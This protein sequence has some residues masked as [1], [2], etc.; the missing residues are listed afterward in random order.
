MKNQ[1]GLEI[2]IIERNAAFER[3]D[4]NYVRSVLG[5]KP[6]DEVVEMSL[7]KAR[8][9]C[10]QISDNVRRESQ[11]W[12]AERGLTDMIGRPVVSGEPLPE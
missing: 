7:H 5:P 4:L 6:S 11:E 1:I 9:D 10:V 2:A 8:L 12:L 3:G